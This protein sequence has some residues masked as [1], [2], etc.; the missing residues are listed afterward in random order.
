MDYSK[1]Y[2][3]DELPTDIFNSGNGDIRNFNGQQVKV[4]NNG[5]GT[6][7]IR[8]LSSNELSQQSTTQALDSARQIRDFNVQSNQPAIQ[9]YEASKNPLQDRY[10]NLLQT[11]K[12]NQQ[13][14]ENRQTTTTNNEMG[15]RGISNDSGVYE[16]E[17]TNAVNPITQQYTGMYGDA[18]AQQGIDMSNIDKAIAML[19]TGNPEAAFSGGMGIQSNVQQAEQQAR[20][21]DLQRQQMLQQG[22]QFDT[23]SALQKA[24]QALS[25]RQFNEISLPESKYATNKP[26]YK[27]AG[28]VNNGW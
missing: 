7:S 9:S 10:K 13:V 26:Y 21:L 15:R 20:N 5:N 1:Q 12:G 23:T 14:A 24:A 3:Q 27:G 19:K 17:M 18:N 2:R 16:Q 11:I 22:S 28:V 8:P 6:R 25:E 4:I